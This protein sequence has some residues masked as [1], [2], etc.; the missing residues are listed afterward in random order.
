MAGTGPEGASQIWSRM[1]HPLPGS[2]V[3]WDSFV[4]ALVGYNRRFQFGGDTPQELEENGDRRRS[5]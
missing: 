3:T 4:G 1:R 5:G 2:C